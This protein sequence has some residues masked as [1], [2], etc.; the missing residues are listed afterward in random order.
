MDKSNSFKQERLVYHFAHV[1]FYNELKEKVSISCNDSLKNIGALTPFAYE[2]AFKYKKLNKGNCMF[3]TWAN[4]T[5]KWFHPEFVEIGDYVLLEMSI[6]NELLIET[7]YDNWCSFI[8]DLDFADGDLE[9]AGEIYREQGGKGG[10]EESYN[11]IFNLTGSIRRQCL[12]PRLEFNWI[13]S[14]RYVKS[15]II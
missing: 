10:I 8:T 4:T 3:F 14:V 12:V 9:V 13:K 5:E 2:Y 15:K 6:P 1:D 11:D 7:D